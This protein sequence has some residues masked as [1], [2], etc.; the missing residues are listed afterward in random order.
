M[1]LLRCLIYLAAVGIISFAA[2]R[3]IPRDILDESCFPFRTYDFEMGGR[4]YDKIGIKYWMNRLPDMSRIFPRLMPSK[5]LDG[6]MSE[7]LPVM[8][9]ETCM[10]EL[11]HILLIPSGFVCLFIWRGTG[12]WIVTAAYEIFN[13]LFIL[14]Q[15]YNR[16][17][18][19]GLYEK[20]QRRTV[21]IEN[22]DTQL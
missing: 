4:I 11:I 12:G 10:A 6:K 18:L 17:R 22:L 16:P 3:L 2:G 9:K 7:K 14:I 8:I 1:G 15:R 19:L 13:F 20:V 21:Q 5:K